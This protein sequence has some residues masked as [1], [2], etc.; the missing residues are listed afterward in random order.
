M[1]ANDTPNGADGDA[2]SWENHR[3][4]VL[5]AAPSD[6]LAVLHCILPIWKVFG[7]DQVAERNKPGMLASCPQQ[8]QPPK[9]T[10]KK[11]GGGPKK[12]ALE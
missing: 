7:E 9:P 3:T 1:I 12:I 2:L 10:Q 6:I 5:S 4:E 8:R 11:T